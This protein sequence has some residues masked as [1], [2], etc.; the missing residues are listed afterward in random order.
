MVLTTAPG[1]KVRGH[2]AET[3]IRTDTGDR[4]II[5]TGAK[6]IIRKYAVG[7]KEGILGCFPE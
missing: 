2:F 3:K 5:E 4:G 7:E 6:G 1:R